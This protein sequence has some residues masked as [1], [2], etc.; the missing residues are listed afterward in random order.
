MPRSGVRN[1]GTVPST[2]RLAVALVAA[3]AGL[4]AS[5]CTQASAPGGRTPGV[6][7]DLSVGLTYDITSIDPAQQIGG[8]AEFGAFESLY[9]YGPGGKLE[10]DLAVSQSHPSPTVYIYDLRHGVK[11]WDGT[12]MTSADVVNALRWEDQP[13]NST[14]GDLTSLKSVAAR[15]PYTVVVTLAA[16]NAAWNTELAAVG[17]IFEKK[18]QQEHGK[19][20]GRPGV[21]AQGT[22]PFEVDSLD[23]TSSLELSANPHWWGGKIN[24]KH[25]SI[26]FFTNETSQNL[27]FK[28]GEIQVAFPSEVR[29]FTSTTGV[30]VKTVPALSEGYFGMNVRLPPWNNVYVRRAVAYALNK[31]AIIAANGSPGD[32]ATD[33]I[34]PSELDL[35]ATPS[36]VD[37]LLKSLPSYPYSVAKAKAELAKSPYPKGFTA[38][39]LTTSYSSYVPVDEVI[40]YDL[41]QI[42]INLVPKT[43]SVDDFFTVTAAAKQKL[44]AV[45]INCNTAAVN[46]PT[47]FPSF[48]L[49][50]DNIQAGYNFANYAPSN[51]DTLIT[52]AVQA[53]GASQ[54]FAIYSKMLHILATDVPYVPLYVQDYAVGLAPQ[55]TW[56]TFNAQYLLGAFELGVQQK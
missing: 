49:G 31:Q 33:L 47:S 3:A 46:D 48:I 51:V 36:Q 2:R 22:G 45:Y 13:A 55:Y 28:A 8:G 37:G 20:M 21:L 4:L 38:S 44:P 52:Q 19:A 10:P 24:V 29:A 15:G 18:F 6:I 16:P 11:F 42:G 50:Q 23:P 56:P 41:K 39:T 25:V 43:V 54:R 53:T 7:Q 14:Y 30:E 9:K 34:P 40:A 32:V 27:A 12:G 5:G 17:F 1:V 35:I 26:K